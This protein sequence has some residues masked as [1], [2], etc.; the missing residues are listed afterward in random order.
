MVCGR[1]DKPARSFVCVLGTALFG[2]D[3][4]EMETGWLLENSDSWLTFLSLWRNGKEIET[5][6]PRRQDLIDP[7]FP[8]YSRQDLMGQLVWKGSQPAL[9]LS[10]FCP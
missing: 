3:R 9:C 5:I 2:K 10:R 1:S 8:R 6:P 4:Y 7:P